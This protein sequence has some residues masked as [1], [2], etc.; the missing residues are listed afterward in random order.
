MRLSELQKCANAHGV[1]IPKRNACGLTSTV[2]KT[3]AGALERMPVARVTNISRTIEELQ[4]QGVWV[5]AVDMD[6][7]SYYETEGVMKGA[8]AL[9]IGMKEKVS[10]GSL[11]RSATSRYQFR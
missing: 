3:S 7:E 1:I 4:A 9:V 2:A 6:G 10:A 5:A 8:I 11:R